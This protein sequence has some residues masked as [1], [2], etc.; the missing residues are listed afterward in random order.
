MDEKLRETAHRLFHTLKGGTT[1]ETWKKFDKE[2]AGELSMF[3]AG[4]LYSAR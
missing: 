4:R 2:L 3:F 1:F